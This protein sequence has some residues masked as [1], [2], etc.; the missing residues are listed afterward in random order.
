MPARTRCNT[1]RR[2]VRTQSLCD[3]TVSVQ[4]AVTKPQTWDETGNC[5]P[6]LVGHP[7]SR[8]LEVAQTLHLERKNFRNNYYK[9]IEDLQ[10]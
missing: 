7:V 9:C 4:C 2:K 6:E 8:E 3:T 5:A 10:G 1:S